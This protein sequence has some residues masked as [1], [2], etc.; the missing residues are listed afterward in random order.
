MRI[1]GCYGIVIFGSAY[2]SINPVNKFG[3]D[4]ERLPEGKGEK[5]MNQGE[6]PKEESTKKVSRRKML[7]ALGAGGVALMTQKIWTGSNVAAANG[8]SVTSAVYGG[9]SCPGEIGSECVTYQ[10]DVGQPERTVQQKLREQVS[11]TDFGAVGDGLTDDSAAFQAAI[12]A[13]TLKG[14][15]R[16]LIPEGTYL[17]YAASPTIHSPKRILITSNHIHIEGIGL[18]TIHM[19]GVSKTYIESINDLNSSGRDLFT[20]FSFMGVSNCSVRGIRFTGEWDGSGTFRYQSPRA[21]AVGFTGCTDCVAEHLYGSHLM[22]NLVNATPASYAHD[23]FYKVASGIRIR[24]CYAEYCLENGYNYMGDTYNSSNS[25]STAKYCGSAGFEAATVNLTVT[26]NVFVHNKYCGL[27]ISGKQVVATSNICSSN[28]DG[29]VPTS[30]TMGSGIAITYFSVLPTS[31]ILLANNIIKDND[32]FGVYVYPGVSKI[33]IE[34]NVISNNSQG[35]TYKMGINL[36]GSATNRIGDVEI[37]NNQLR[38]DAGYTT[39]FINISY[40]YQIKVANNRCIMSGNNMAYAQGTT[41]DC[42][43][44]GNRTNRPILVSPSAIDC[45]Q[46]DNI[47][48][49]PKRLIQTAAP[50]TG[51]WNI[52]DNVQNAAPAGAN[53]V[54][55]WVCTAAGT[56]TPSTT[57][58]S[59]QSYSAGVYTNANSKVYRAVKS[60]V[61]G[62]SSPNHSSGVVADGT[63]LWEYVSAYSTPV[64]KPY[65]LLRQVKSG[66]AEFSGDGI[67]VVYQIT[68]GLSAI[69][70][71]YQVTPASAGSGAA[72]IAYVDADA[73]F[74]NVH[75]SS[76]PALGAN[77][78][79]LVWSAD[80]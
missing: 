32:G 44:Y 72:G 23:G 65:G 21:K 63:V 9:A 7:A 61:S 52:G 59:S 5:R 25:D 33:T 13:L 45:Y 62:T 56:F 2:Q 10:Y 77:N 11:V 57:W 50:M 8:L 49:N 54:M 19:T 48:I 28:G 67:T 20:V 64:F 69:P 15:G 34:G 17:F 31:D 35:N 71:S 1:Q 80:C 70:Q 39:Y 46:Y 55:G 27:S 75:F 4:R 36:V 47:G 18:P 22:G 6:M 41:S 66:N 53:A 30:S 73:T 68:H 37:S 40:A 24:S 3:D 79:V 12:D 51:T 38:D 60:G 42:V 58:G 16:L 78:V 74:L 26:G 14:G 76:A 29:G 43:F